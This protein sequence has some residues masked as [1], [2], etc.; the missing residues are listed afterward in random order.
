MNAGDQQQE[1]PA[2]CGTSQGRDKEHPGLTL[3]VAVPALANGTVR[4]SAAFLP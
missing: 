4:V 1:R 3:A 2:S